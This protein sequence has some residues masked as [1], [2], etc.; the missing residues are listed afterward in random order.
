MLALPSA[1][2]A[3]NVLDI[4]PLGIWEQILSHLPQLDMAGLHGASVLS[5]QNAT[6]A[7]VCRQFNIMVQLRWDHLARDVQ[8]MIA[9]CNLKDFV[10]QRDHVPAWHNL[11]E[12][13]QLKDFQLAHLDS[14]FWCSE[15][16]RCPGLCPL[17]TAFSA[18]HGHRHCHA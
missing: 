10:H 18:S 11:Y 2:P 3:E 8:E 6:I 5:R 15:T 16:R 12:R 13:L 1:R 9:A 14:S 4:L 17:G 7:G